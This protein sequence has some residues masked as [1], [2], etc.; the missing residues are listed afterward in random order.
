MRVVLRSKIHRAF[1]TGHNEDYVGSVII[2]RALME[3]VDLWEYEKVLICDV[4]NGNRWETYVLPG[5]YGEGE[6]SVQGAG[7]KLCDDGDCL[8]IL[9]FEVSDEPVEPK[10]ILVDQNNRFVEYIEAG[11][12]AQQVH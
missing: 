2:D 11:H 9:S 3:K 6:V 7:A 8:I 4:T 12:H 10:M 5:L 1:V